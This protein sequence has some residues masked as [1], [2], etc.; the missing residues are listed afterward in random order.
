MLVQEMRRRMRD[1]QE[2]G[3]ILMRWTGCTVTHWQEEDEEEDEVLNGTN[4][5]KA[6]GGEGQQVHAHQRSRSPLLCSPILLSLSLSSHSPTHTGGA[7]R[8]VATN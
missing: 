4:Q 2:E 7:S 3:T 1:E 5:G 8:S 6:K